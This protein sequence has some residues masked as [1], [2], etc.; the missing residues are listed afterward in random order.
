MTSLTIEQ[1]HSLVQDAIRGLEAAMEDIGI[2]REDLFNDT[3]PYGKVRLN[4]LVHMGL[5]WGY[6]EEGRIP[7]QH[8]WHRYG[9]DYGASI[10]DVADVRPTAIGDLP[11]PDKPSVPS[12]SGERR[13]SIREYFNFYR[14]LIEPSL[15]KIA[16]M[17]IHDFLERFY[18]DYAPD[19]YRS[20][21]LANVDLQRRLHHDS[22]D[23]NPADIGPKEYHEIGNIVTKL[24]REL[25]SC[26]DIAVRE[27]AKRVIE[28]TNL[29]EDT[30]MMIAKV[31]PDEIPTNTEVVIR[32]F[33]RI[34][35]ENTWK[36]VSEHISEH[37][38][39]GLNA[40]DIERAASNQQQ[41]LEDEF[42]PIPDSLLKIVEDANLLPG[43]RDYEKMS[44]TDHSD[45]E[46]IINLIDT[47]TD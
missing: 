33:G 38:A 1:E 7:I 14:D 3:E 46:K 4:K 36:Y 24:H 26:E 45:G 23:L 8:S 47:Y 15:N 20:L 9:A 5:V 29:L 2:S 40:A 43:P 22:K 10:P 28:F 16:E 37:T 12:Q 25:A 27:A 17:A 35:H 31:S 32:E 13:P 18:T 19:V 44:G 21:Y 30:Y 6:E 41:L 39:Q 34:Y 42:N 11:E